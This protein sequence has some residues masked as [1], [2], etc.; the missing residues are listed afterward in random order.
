MSAPAPIGWPTGRITA[1]RYL[2]LVD[3]GLLRPD[4][5]VELLEGVVAAMASSGPRH[6]AAVRRMTLALVR[7]VGDRAVV[8]VR[9]TFVAGR[10]SVPEP[11]LALLPGT[12]E[13]YDAVHPTDALLA[14]EAPD[15]SLPQ[16]RITKTAIYAGAG[17]PEYWIVNL[18]QDVVEVHRRV[19]RRT[20]RYRLRSVA[21]RGETLVPLALP[22]VRIAVDAI[23]PR[24]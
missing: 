4:D 16:D 11:D 2:R 17:I 24:R 7:A 23:M 8:S 5:K 15:S 13:D 12:L 19:D 14:V 1:S 10:W 6:A 9:L 3:E 21:Q 20:R 22:D 18:R